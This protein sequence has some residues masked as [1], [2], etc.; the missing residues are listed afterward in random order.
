MEH[1]GYKI[2][3]LAVLYDLLG[4]FLVASND[5]WEKGQELNHLDI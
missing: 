3:S 1:M 5:R 4:M 2:D